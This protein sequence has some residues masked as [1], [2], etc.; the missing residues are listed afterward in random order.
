M[1]HRGEEAERQASVGHLAFF[2]GRAGPDQNFR[3]ASET[4]NFAPVALSLSTATISIPGEPFRNRS[5]RHELVG[6][7]AGVTQSVVS[8]ERVGCRV[9]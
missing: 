3:A 4:D 2:S 5:P 1:Q 7:D 6:A 8:H 9:V